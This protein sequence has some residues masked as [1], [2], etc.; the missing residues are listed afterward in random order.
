MGQIVEIYQ[1]IEVTEVVIEKIYV[2]IQ[3]AEKNGDT[4]KVENLKKQ[5]DDHK[6][7]IDD[8]KK[9]EKKVKDDHKKKTEEIVSPKVPEI[10][11]VTDNAV[12]KVDKYMKKRNQKKDL[13]KKKEEHEKLLEEAKTTGDQELITYYTTEITT[14]IEEYNVVVEEVT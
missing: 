2:E 7:K 4:G 14:V 1:V 6:K 11:K 13:E 10:H 8:M 9:K 5:V 12:E 3:T